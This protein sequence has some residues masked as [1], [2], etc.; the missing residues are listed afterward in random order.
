[1][2]LLSPEQVTMMKPISRAWA[3]LALLLPLAYSACEDDPSEPPFTPP[4]N[5]QVTAT[6]PS[7]ARVTYGAVNGATSYVIERATG[8]GTFASAGTS[9]TTTFDDTGLSPSTS[10]RY[11][12]AAVRGAEQTAFSTEASVTT[13]APGTVTINADITTNRTLSSDTIYRLSGFI[14]VTNGATL[15]IQAGT[16][17]LGDYDVLGSSLFV[18]RGAR[19][20]ALG[21][22]ARPIVFTS[23]RPAGQRQSGDWGGVVIVGNAP[24]NRTGAIQVEGTGTG[25]SNPALTYD[26]GTN[27][28]DNSGELHYVRIEFAGYAPVTDAELNALTLA[29]VGN[30]TQID[31]VQTLAGLD[32]SFE[33]FGGAV[34]AKY[35]VSY[36]S[37]DDHF[38]I[39]EGYAGRLQFLVA[40]QNRLVTPR[41]NAG[42]LG[43]DPQGIENDGCGSNTGSGCTGGYNS[44]PLN[45]PVVANFTLVG[46][47]VLGTG[48]GDIGMVLRRGTGGY[49]VNGVVSRWARAGISVRDAQTQ[50][51]ITDGDLVLK[52]ILIAESPVLYQTGQQ[53]GVDAT[54][55]NLTLSAATPTALFTAL[56]ASPANGDALDWTP[57][58]NAASR[59]G[60]LTTFTGKL[61]T[62][63]GTFVTGTSYLG[64]A[65]PSGAKWW[66]GWTN[67]AVN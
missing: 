21:T 9:N 59:T 48:S 44:T 24:I 33:W 4:T 39:S 14:H 47:G 50:Q 46:R 54:T 53:V 8:T 23:S 5:V 32:D 58:A 28:A 19:I 60:G 65:D 36:D 11:R 2:A 27:M 55:N 67:Y 45:T 12:V 42:S 35:L 51:R 40:L 26:G 13:Q 3:G 56:P 25:A 16:T 62:A 38:D 18:M 43:S 1:L 29:A 34:D 6:G 10:Y 15:T 20:R 57:A 31:H 37:G 52:N 30:G 41:L 64:A 49:Y 17:I 61:Q 66:Q 63:A 22:A 7:T